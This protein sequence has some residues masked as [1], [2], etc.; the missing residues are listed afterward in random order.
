METAIR[1]KPR[2]LDNDDDADA[3][4]PEEFSVEKVL[5]SRIRNGQKEYLLKWKGYSND[6]NTWEPEENLDCPDLIAAYENSKRKERRKRLSIDGETKSNKRK[7]IEEDNR[8]RGFDRHLEPERILGA[9]DAS[10]ELM[11]LMKWKGTLEADLVTARQAN[12][13]CPDVVISFYEQRLS[14]RHIAVSE[15][16]QRR[17][18]DSD[19]RSESATFERDVANFDSLLSTSPIPPY[20]SKDDTSTTET[21]TNND[22]IEA[23]SNSAGGDTTKDTPDEASK[24]NDDDVPKDDENTENTSDVPDDSTEKETVDEEPAET[25]STEKPAEEMEIEN[26]IADPAIE[27]PDSAV[28]ASDSAVEASDSAVEASDS[29]VEASDTAIEATDPVID[30]TD[31]DPAIDEL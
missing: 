30:A 13:L 10:G 2:D 15:R 25:A 23:E 7:N 27:A 4:A 29:A 17:L 8:P 26:E 31:P 11:F 22:A 28:E 1:G 3:G 12:K 24:E 5:D 6:D 18:T 21:P 9:T 14:Y 16:N 20:T 19:S